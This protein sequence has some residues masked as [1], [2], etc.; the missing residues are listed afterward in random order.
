MAELMLA[1]DAELAPAIKPRFNIGAGLDIP[2]GQWLK[3]KY[4]EYVLN[5]GFGHVTGM[6]GIGN[7]FKS[8]SLDGMELR[9]MSCVLMSYR[10]P[11]KK[12]DRVLRPFDTNFSEYDTEVN[13]N[14]EHKQELVENIPGLAGR[15]FFDFEKPMWRISDKTQYAGDE[16][17]DKMKAFMLHKIKNTKAYEVFTPFLDRDGVTLFKM[18][19]PTYGKVDSVT[20]FQSKVELA[21][22]DKTKL[23]ESDAN[24]LHM[25][26]GLVKTR[27]MSELPPLATAAAHYCGLTA[28]LGKELSIGAAPGQQP[29]KILQ[30]LK[31]GDRIVGATRK[32][33]FATTVCW[34][35]ANAAP[36]VDGD[37]KA[38]YADPN[39]EARQVGD[40]DLNKVVLTCLRNKNGQTGMNLLIIVSQRRG[41]QFSLTEFHNIREKGRYGIVGTG[42]NYNLALYPDCHITRNTIRDK[43][44]NDQKLCNAIRYTSEMQQMQ[45]FHVDLWTEY[46]VE[47]T[48]LYA[49]LK[50]KGYDWDLLLSCR[51]WWALNNDVHPVPFLSTMDLLRMHKG[52][53]HPYWM[54]ED[55]KGI[56]PEF[57][58]EALE[59]I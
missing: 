30:N 25:K 40:T 45:I 12:S 2:T 59:V 20:D 37:R 31:G 18:I 47:P 55:K 3:G 36:L 26:G 53:Y 7:N 23:G 24:T 22:Q 48:E 28:Q 41:I 15:D 16:Y 33:T 21:M 5:G 46:G 8:T 17:F 35:A 34:N 56:K 1:P 39:D 44:D 19:M 10:I 13:T 42:G 14:E 38:E 51:P 52:E 43:I 32:F 9:A 4:G 49:S 57:Q 54:T 58:Y 29:T 50:A 6:V 27:L 11:E